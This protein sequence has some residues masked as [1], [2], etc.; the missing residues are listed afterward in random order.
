M[1]KFIVIV[2]SALF[3]LTFAGGPV[4]A[5][6]KKSKTKTTWSAK[7]SQKDYRI[8]AGDVLEITTW[9]EPGFTRE[10][11]LVR[12]DGQ[13][14]FPLLNDVQAAGLSPVELKRA[15]EAGLK[16]YVSNPVVTVHVT[17]PGS[18]RFYILGEVMRTGEYP[19]IKH[20][21]VLQAFAVAGG[22]TEWASKKEII[23]LRHENGKDKIYRINYKN[24]VKGKDLSQN[25][26]LKTDDTIIVP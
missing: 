10:N 13:I 24:I 4:Q 26:K 2:I 11:V 15:L 18:Q 17:N 5:G 12:S 9:K 23:V 25:L 3:C 7:A 16:E 19:L 20:M 6:K 14:S 22:F 21:T 1:K 8:G